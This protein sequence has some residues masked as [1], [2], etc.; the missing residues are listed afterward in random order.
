MGVH[1]ALGATRGSAGVGEHGASVG[2]VGELGSWAVHT[3]RILVG[4]HVHGPPRGPR[5]PRF[6]H[7]KA[8][9][10]RCAKP[11]LDPGPAL[12]VAEDGRGAAVPS[13]RQDLPSRA[14]I[15]QGNRDPAGSPDRE[16]RDHEGLVVGHDDQHPL[17]GPYACGGQCRRHIAGGPAQIA[18]TDRRA[19]GDQGDVLIWADIQDLRQ[20]L[21]RRIGHPDRQAAST[22]VFRRTASSVALMNARVRSG[23]I[24]E[25]RSF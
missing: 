25:R 14:A 23:S 18:V 19:T 17:A 20:Q 7:G 10:R 2:V 12:A 21:R 1:H 15:V 9:R 11:R 22:G 5:R 16:D 6:D 4:D 24:R 8:Q 3:D 13:D